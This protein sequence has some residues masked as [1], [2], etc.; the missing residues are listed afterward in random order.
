MR[1]VE[2]VVHAA[3]S[4]AA[5]NG[6]VLAIPPSFRR[7][8]FIVKGSSGI[9]SGAVQVETADEFDYAGTWAPISGGPVTAVASTD[10]LIEFEGLYNFLRC[11][12]ST[13]IGGGTIEV[14]YQGS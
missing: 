4:S 14:T 2:F 1:G 11:R 12:I 9:A 3:G 10:V 6:Q 7:H 13:L 8:K 5:G